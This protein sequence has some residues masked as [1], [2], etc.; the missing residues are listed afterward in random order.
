MKRL[1]LLLALLLG[2]FLVPVQAHEL[3]MAEI[4]VREVG[5]GD[6]LWQWTA[7]G[8]V[9]AGQEL[10]VTWPTG[11]V[12]QE[13]VLHCGKEGLK[14]EIRIDG[15]GDSYSAAI[16][17]LRWQDG[18]DRAFTLTSRQPVARVFGSAEDRRG[19]WEVAGSYLTLGVEH[20]LSGLDH[21][22]FVI[23]LLFLVGFRKQLVVTITAFTVAHSLTLALSALGWLTL[24]PAP[25][26]ATIALSIMLVAGE[27]LHREQTLSRRWPAVVAFLF[28]LMHG[29]GFAG[30]LAEIGLPKQH[31]LMA[32]LTFNVGVEI[33]Q[34][35]VVGSSL[36]LYRALART[37]KFDWLR[38]PALYGIGALAGYWSIE[39]AV[40]IFG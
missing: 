23:G 8:N 40:A 24:R 5:A 38:T 15:I 25:V 34:L 4:E 39:R 36:L 32:L 2:L 19:A 21:L 26:E 20:I 10:S 31:F 6:F 29:L 18:G 37:G 9:P 22:L 14:G 12:A 7:S 13:S 35:L 17:R 16:L 33:G 1:P 3:T 27:A 11:C 28:G 30:A